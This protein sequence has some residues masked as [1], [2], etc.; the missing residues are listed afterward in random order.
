MALML[1]WLGCAKVSIIVAL[2]VSEKVFQ[3]ER[4]ALLSLSHVEAGSRGRSDLTWLTRKSAS[5]S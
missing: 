2:S 1:R 5:E 4:A 3:L